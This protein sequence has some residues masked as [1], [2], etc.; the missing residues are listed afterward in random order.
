MRA[1]DP[2]NPFD[3]RNYDPNK[4]YGTLTGNGVIPYAVKCGFCNDTIVVRGG[5]T[6]SLDGKR[7]CG[8]QFGEGRSLE[9]R[10]VE[11]ME[12]QAAALEKLAAQGIRGFGDPTL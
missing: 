5:I 8:C 3:L 12:R 2:S 9:E 4:V 11:A 6:R 10:R 7:H 1:P